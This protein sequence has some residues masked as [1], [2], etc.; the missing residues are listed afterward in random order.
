MKRYMHLNVQST[1]VYNSQ[2]M[3]TTQVPINSRMGKEDV[4]ANSCVDQ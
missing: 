4:V 3:E 2:D 1:T